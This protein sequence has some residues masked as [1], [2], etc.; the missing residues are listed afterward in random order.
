M[1]KVLIGILVLVLAFFG[2]EIYFEF[3]YV[4]PCILSEAQ[5]EALALGVWE[6]PLG[7]YASYQFNADGTGMLGDIPVRWEVDK[8][9]DGS[10]VDAYDAQFRLHCTSM[11]QEGYYSVYFY[12]YAD[13]DHARAHSYNIYNDKGTVSLGSEKDLYPDVQRESWIERFKA[14][15]YE[16]VELDR[17]NWETYFQI[18][19][20]P[21]FSVSYLDPTDVQSWSYDN[22]VTLKPEYIPRTLSM[23]NKDYT[24][25]C[26]YEY[27]T[28]P[29]TATAN[30]GK[31]SVTLVEP[32]TNVEGHYDIFQMGISGDNYYDIL[33]GGIH[34]DEEDYVYGVE[35]TKIPVPTSYNDEEYGTVHVIETYT[36][37]DCRGRILILK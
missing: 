18:I 32:Q 12:Y 30:Y 8:R 21:Y 6:D 14:G 29:Y 13:T 31:N 23:G 37:H 7:D 2:A 15:T 10:D 24:Y 11:G 5:C 25:D 34:L 19:Q 1:K 17:T 35:L 27:T 9:S 22:Y 26:L 28:T 16:L 36:L 20:K 33:F 3:F 4:Y